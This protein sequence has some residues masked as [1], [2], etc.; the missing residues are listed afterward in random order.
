MRVGF[1]GR[2]RALHDSILEIVDEGRHEVC[3]IWTSRENDYDGA[4]IDSFRVLAKRVGCPFVV[5]PRVEDDCEIPPGIDVICSVNFVN[6]IPR[7]FLERIPHGVLN[8][9]LGDLPLYR[10]NACPNW[11]ILNC[12]E[13]V[14]LVVHAM[15]ENLDSGPIYWV[16]SMG[17][18]D[19]TYVGDV[20]DWLNSRVPVGFREALLAIESGEEPLPQRDVRPLRTFPRREEDSRILWNRGPVEVCRLVRASSR[21]FPG[22]FCHLNGDDETMVRVLAAESVELDYDIL[23]VDGQVLFRDGDS[24]VVSSLN[25]AVRVTKCAVNGQT[26][27]DSVDFVTSSL[28]N[29]L[30][31]WPGR[32]R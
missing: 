14:G 26:H 28:R 23:A 31:S 5:S 13:Q 10:G 18:T 4:D 1:M 17:L 29:R 25:R 11:A 32:L 8:A 7:W 22:A 30:T 16:D 3:L 2:S 24:F 12:E 6:L 27:A 19:Q 9:H 21:P 15:N 20:Y